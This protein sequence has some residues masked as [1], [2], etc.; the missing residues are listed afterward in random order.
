MTD[1][2]IKSLA[3]TGTVVR[4][5]RGGE[6][7]LPWLCGIGSVGAWLTVGDL[8][9][10][11]YAL[12]ASKLA[13]PPHPD[14]LVVILL[15]ASSL[16]LLLA[17][18]AW[19]AWKP[20]SPH[21][22]TAA[23]WS[24]WLMVL[25]G[26]G[27]GGIMLINY[28]IPAQAHHLDKFLFGLLVAIAWSGWFLAR[29]QGLARA[30]DCRPVRWLD[31][32]LVNLLV[33]LLVGEATV[34][35][36]DPLLARSGLFG[37]KHTPANLKPHIPVRG[38]IGVSNTQGFRDRERVMERTSPAPR[39]LAL[40]DSFTWGAGVSYD[41][42]FVTLIERRLQTVA[43]EAEVINVGVPAW[44]LQ[45]ELH[46]LK[47]YGIRFQPDLVVLNFFIGNDI[48][49]KRGD[50]LSLPQLLIVAGQSYYVHSNGN[51]LHDRIGP[52]RWYLYHDLNFLFRI[53]GA[54]VR[55]ALNGKG[56]SAFGAMSS[57]ESAPLV[58]RAQYVR[59][60]YER[61]DIYLAEDTRFFAQHWA[62]TQATLLALWAFL[63]ERGI[64]LLLV[65]IPDHV[66]LDRALQTEYLAG[67]GQAADQ[68]DFYKPQ[69]LLLAWC[70]ERGIPTVALLPAFEAAGSPET[71][72]FRND[73]HLT[74]S[75]H[76]LAAQVVA[77]AL[78]AQLGALG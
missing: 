37:D 42:A 44:G 61:S 75:G 63:S 14:L 70:Q 25:W 31:I 50:D 60:I 64:P 71:L 67:I 68:Y 4:Q 52:D 65:I 56:D 54:R 76:R 16:G 51:W 55:Q 21:R 13:N 73:F 19:Q 24:P 23:G 18:A 35:L 20:D 62:R 7:I 41:E 3:A 45:E 34:R 8:V 5:G 2:F 28:P 38:T 39:V 1:P 77:P 47:V 10:Y 43:P 26:V 11:L 48:Q 72:Y 53:G 6:A 59:G 22:V 9:S 12:T 32:A 27:F 15:V 33:F 66:Q 40:G 58:S 30:V 17:L 78:Q 69:R 57:G 46:L 49:N 29:P 36:L 74:A